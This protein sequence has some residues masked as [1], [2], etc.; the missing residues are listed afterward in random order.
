MALSN[1]LHRGLP[2]QRLVGSEMV[3]R[4]HPEGC[5]ASRRI[6]PFPLLKGTVEVG[7]FQLPII[8]LIELLAVSPLGSLYMAVELGGARWQ[9]EEADS[10]LQ[11][12]LFSLQ[13]PVGKGCL[14]LRAPV[15]L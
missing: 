7:D 6:G 11:A 15:H 13:D 5:S 4:S 3:V 9:D 1:I 12:G 8:E 10:S 2:V 14:E